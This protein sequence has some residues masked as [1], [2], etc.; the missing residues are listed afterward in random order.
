[1]TTYNCYAITTRSLQKFFS[2]SSQITIYTFS[3]AIGQ[4]YF[5]V[6]YTRHNL[7]TLIIIICVELY[8]TKEY[9]KISSTNRHVI[10]RGM[11]D[12]TSK[13]TTSRRGS[14]MHILFL[15]LKNLSRFLYTALEFSNNI[16]IFTIRGRM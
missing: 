7:H 5:Q 13:K 15:K 16:F 12:L 2:V 14:F 4:R 10:I 11:Y 3:Y 6:T 9:Y 8:S 1:M